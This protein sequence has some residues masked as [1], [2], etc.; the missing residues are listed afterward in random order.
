MKILTSELDH[1][2]LETVS[3]LPFMMDA[4]GC[5]SKREQR[6]GALLLL[7]SRS[8]FSIFYRTG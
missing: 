4:G 2:L 7:S 8:G 6:Y 1:D 5:K 3:R